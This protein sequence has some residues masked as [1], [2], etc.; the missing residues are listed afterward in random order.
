VEATTDE[1]H[2]QP[3]YNEGGPFC[4][5]KLWYPDFAIAGYTVQGKNITQPNSTT[6]AFEPGDVWT[7][8]Y[9]GALLLS[10]GWA[11]MS[12]ALGSR[13][14]TVRGPDDVDPVVNPD[15][16]DSLA[17]RAWSKLRPKVEKAGLAQAVLELR[18]A[19]RMLKGTA[20]SAVRS[21]HALKAFK[22]ST[23]FRRQRSA[24]GQIPDLRRVPK[25]I[26]EEFLNVQFG[27]KPFV[28]EVV[29]VL[30][31]VI[32]LISRTRRGGTTSGRSGTG[33][34]KL[35]SRV[36]SCIARAG[37]RSRVLLL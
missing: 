28:R 16:L 35:S 27:W 20:N 14:Q 33:A 9:S 26:A 32:N 37:L 10:S 1:N 3:P 29:A 15:D 25:P 22:R 30:D 2:G 34:K 21:W 6:G 5:V 7:R 13:E 24:F 17:P 12:T 19:P 8:S 31:V 4:S 36:T 23:Q 18:E 11:Y